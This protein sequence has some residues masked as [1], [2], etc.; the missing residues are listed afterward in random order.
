MTGSC[1]TGPLRVGRPLRGAYTGLARR[2]ALV[3]PLVAKDYSDQREDQCR[4]LYRGKLKRR[5]NARATRS[6][7]VR[8]DRSLRGGRSD[9]AAGD[10][11]AGVS[12]GVGLHVVGLLVHH[13]GGAAVGND[14]V[15][16]GGIEGEVIHIESGLT[17]VAFADHDVLGKVAGVVAHGI[18]RAVLLVLGIE[19]AGGSL[20]VG[21]VAEGLGVDVD[22]V[23]A[24]RKIF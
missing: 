19:V 7:P 15:R 11:V 5:V 1:R 9:D 6:G 20:E 12:G 23:L 21:G 3:L 2:S 18:E 10:A 13:D 17:G 4:S 22:S 14:A 16:G 8:Q 24:D